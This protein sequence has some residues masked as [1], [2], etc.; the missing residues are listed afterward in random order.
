MG[1][2][3]R[4]DRAFL[5]KPADGGTSALLTSSEHHMLLEKI[6]D[7]TELVQQRYEAAPPVVQRQRDPPQQQ[8]GQRQQQGRRQQQQR[9]QSPRGFRMGVQSPPAVRYDRIYD[10]I[11]EGV[12]PTHYDTAQRYAAAPSPIDKYTFDATD[13][14]VALH[15]PNP[16]RVQMG[17]KQSSSIY[18]GSG[19]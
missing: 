19:G 10:R 5:A 14:S 4:R 2:D 12:I 3:G 16:A 18:P 11:P 1:V 13:A 17:N 15:C 8:R 7:L 6:K 9:G